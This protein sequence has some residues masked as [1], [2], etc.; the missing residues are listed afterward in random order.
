[1]WRSLRIRAL[2]IPE[3]E[4]GNVFRRPIGWSG[5][6]RRQEADWAS[7]LVAAI[8]DLH[9]AGVELTDNAPG[10]RSRCHSRAGN[11]RCSV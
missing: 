1:M 10:L 6:D 7:S 9:G 2:G 8:A 3:D 11:K 4:R 5:S